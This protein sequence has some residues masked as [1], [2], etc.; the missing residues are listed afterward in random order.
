MLGTNA[1]PFLDFFS[2]FPSCV[3]FARYDSQPYLRRVYVVQMA[4]SPTTSHHSTWLLPDMYMNRGVYLAFITQ[5]L[6]QRFFPRSSHVWLQRGILFR[7]HFICNRTGNFTPGFIALDCE[8]R[9][10]LVYVTYREQVRSK[11]GPEAHAA[12]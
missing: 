7:V 6:E 11:S 9:G 3:H 1:I 4:R 8:Q 12:W 5:V 10:A 2:T